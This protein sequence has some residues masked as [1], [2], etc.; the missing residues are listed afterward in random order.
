M[1]ILATMAFGRANYFIGPPALVLTPNVG[2]NRR[3]D[4]T[5]TEDEGMCRRVRL[6]ARLGLRNR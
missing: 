5:A 1:P 6:T 4:E 3:A 2:G